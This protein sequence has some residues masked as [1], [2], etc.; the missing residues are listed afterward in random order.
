MAEILKRIF[1]E[2][3]G[4]FLSVDTK[5]VT[6]DIMHGRFVLKQAAIKA[7]VFDGLHLPFTLRGGF[8]DEISINFKLGLFNVGAAAEVVVKNVFFVVGP[9][10]T[11]WSWEHVQQCKTKL[12]D[13]ILSGSNCAFQWFLLISSRRVS[14]KLF[15]DSKYHQRTSS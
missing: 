4:Y 11:D 5:N 10:T 13:L 9:H 6:I 15:R 3:A 1:D 7:S 8:I 2:K 12:I 14:E